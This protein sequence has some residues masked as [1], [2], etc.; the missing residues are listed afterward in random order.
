MRELKLRSSSLI[1][2]GQ[3]SRKSSD[4]RLYAGG[5]RSMK[6]PLVSRL[7]SSFEL[8]EELGEREEGEEE[9]ELSS[10]PRSLLAPGSFSD[11]LSDAMYR[12][13]VVWCG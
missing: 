10:L 4:S 13:C 5:D 12:W 9:E 3:W 1:T 8:I 7:S 2:L 11:C 6:G